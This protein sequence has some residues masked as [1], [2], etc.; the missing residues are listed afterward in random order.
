[1]RCPSCNK[2]TAFNLDAEPEVEIEIDTEGH[3]SGSVRLVNACVDCDSELKEAYFELCCDISAENH[4]D[5]EK[6]H[7]LGVETTNIERTMR[8]G[9]YGKKKEWVDSRH[10]RTYYGAVVDYHVTCLCGE[11]DVDKSFSCEIGASDM[12]ELK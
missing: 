1:M 7:E 8:S 12:E 3:V 5:E 2:F 4:D 10:G 6:G 11:L 9:Y